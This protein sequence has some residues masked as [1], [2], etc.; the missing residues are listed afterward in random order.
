MYLYLLLLVVDIIICIVAVKVAEVIV[1]DVVKDGGG[2]KRIDQNPSLVIKVLDSGIM[3]DSICYIY[4]VL[5]ITGQLG[6]DLDQL[7]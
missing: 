7:L 3:Q 2:Q 5:E 1:T 6:V 4:S